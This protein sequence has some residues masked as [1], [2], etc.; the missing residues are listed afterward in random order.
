MPVIDASGPVLVPAERG[1]QAFPTDSSSY[2]T[3]SSTGTKYPVGD[4]PKELGELIERDVELHH[5]WDG[6]TLSANV[7]AEVISRPCSISTTLPAGYY[8]NLNNRVHLL[9]NLLLHGPRSTYGMQSAGDPT[10]LAPIA[11]TF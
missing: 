9:N 4:V 6:M 2:G 7:V 1:T 10:N 11:S 3:C 5:T 8:F